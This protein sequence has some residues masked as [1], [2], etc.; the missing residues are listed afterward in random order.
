MEVKG[1]ALTAPKWLTDSTDIVI[2]DGGADGDDSGYRRCT[3]EIGKAAFA[4]SWKTISV[5]GTVLNR[6]AGIA[7]AP[8]PLQ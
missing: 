5:P 3:G 8:R 1:E 2:P 4:N 7:G 6:D